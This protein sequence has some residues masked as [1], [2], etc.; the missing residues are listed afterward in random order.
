MTHAFCF[1]CSV[2]RWVRQ[3]ASIALVPKKTLA[4]QARRGPPSDVA[5]ISGE[6]E[7]GAAASS[8]GLAPQ[9]MVP[10]PLVGQAIGEAEEAPLEVAAQPTME[11]MPLPTSGRAELSTAP[12]A[13]TTAAR[14]T[15]GRGPTDGGGGDGGYDWWVTARSCGGG[16]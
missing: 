1:F 10:M 15:T 9:A 5:P 13:S 3:G 7:A 8:T 6:S 14:G 12:V 2:G 16:A 11:V 4:L